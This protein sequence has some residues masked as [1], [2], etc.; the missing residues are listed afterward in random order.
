RA[1]ADDQLGPTLFRRCTHLVEVDERRVAVDSV[2]DEVVEL[3][4][5]VDLEAVREMPAVV[6]T[7]GENGVPRLE[8]AE[9]DGHVRLRAGMRLHVRVV[10]AEEL[11]GAVDRELLDLVDDFAATVVAPS[12]IALGVLV[13]RHAAHSLEHA[14]P[15]EVL[16]GDQLYLAALALELP[17]EEGS[18][19]GIN[20]RQPGPLQLLQGL[21]RDGHGST[22]PRHP[23]TK[24]GA[25]SLS[26]RAR[27]GRARPAREPLPPARPRALSRSGR[28]RSRAC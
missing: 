10:G 21:L 16:R 24:A 27:F 14:W 17:L 5:E 9:V 23:A 26:S 12:G 1:A 11:L 25:V 6:E 20:L 2:A 4:G 18:G 15:G 13:R 3:S 8:A 7:H 28:S 19:L 22:I